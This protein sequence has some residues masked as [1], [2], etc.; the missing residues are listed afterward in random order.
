MKE[1]IGGLDRGIRI[2]IGLALLSL[3]FLLDG[4]S[5]FFGLIGIIPIATALIK[6][7]PLYSIFGFSSCPAKTAKK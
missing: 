6:S 1:N 5:R 4:G 7:C 3:L 2:V